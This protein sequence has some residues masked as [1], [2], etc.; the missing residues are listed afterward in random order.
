M[1]VVKPLV[2]TLV[3]EIT[4]IQEAQQIIPYI[5]KFAAVVHGLAIPGSEKKA[6][7]I[8]GLHTLVDELVAADK[9]SAA[10]KSDVDRFIDTVVPITIDTMI[11]VVKGAFDFKKTVAGCLP[12]LMSLLCGSRA[13]QVA[14]AVNAPKVTVAADEKVAVTAAEAV[15]ET[16]TEAVATKQELS[17]IVGIVGITDVVVDA[18]AA[19]NTVVE[20]SSVSDAKKMD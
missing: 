14:V 7:V 15:A 2:L 4:T 6:V 11:D 13:A 5:P 10:I 8:T 18:A 9:L 1:A 3:A 16:V 17:E 12:A 19:T 20:D